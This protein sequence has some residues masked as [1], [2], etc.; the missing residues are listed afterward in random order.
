[1]KASKQIDRMTSN[2]DSNQ[3][4]SQPT[5]RQFLSTGSA[6]SA[7]VTGSMLL[8]NAVR[9]AEPAE[10]KGQEIRIGIVGLGGRGTGALNNT[11]TINDNVKL[12][13]TA[14]VDPGKYRVLDRLDKYGD[15]IDVAEGKNHIGIDAYKKVLDDP[16]VDLV[17]FTT[18]TITAN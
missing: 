17:I 3:G 4:E 8:G 12:V 10:D 5:R 2:S 14:D 15:K 7:G 16:D 13:A 1:M 9:G 6:V 11:L 18:H